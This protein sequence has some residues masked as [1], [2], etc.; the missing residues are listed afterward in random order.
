MKTS[1]IITNFSGGEVSRKIW[2][3]V[4]T[5]S[6]QNGCED[7]INWQ[8]DPHG[9]VL[10][11]AG[12]LFVAPTKFADKPTRL[13]PFVFSREDSYVL[14]FGDYYMRLYRNKGVVINPG[15]FVLYLGDG[16]ITDFF[17]PHT[18]AEV[19]PAD[20][21]VLQNGVEKTITTDYTVADVN[22]TDELLLPFNDPAWVNPSDANYSAFTINGSQATSAGG[23]TISRMHQE[24]TLGKGL[25][26]YGGIDITAVTYEETTVNDTNNN[27]V[28]LSQ[29]FTKVLEF[30]PSQDISQ[31]GRYS[32]SLTFEDVSQQLRTSTFNWEVRQGST[33]LN[34]GS[35]L[36]V[37]TPRTVTLTDETIASITKDEAL[38]VY[39][40]GVGD[41]PQ[42]LPILSGVDFPATFDVTG[43]TDPNAAIRIQTIDSKGGVISKVDAP[44]V[45]GSYSGD[46]AE[47]IPVNRPGPYYMVIEV[48]PY[49]QVTFDNPSLKNAVEGQMVTFLTAPADQDI[50]SLSDRNYV[51]PE[52]EAVGFA[53]QAIEVFEVETPYS[54]DEVFDLYYAQANDVMYIAH[55]DHKPR[56]L[57]RHNAYDWRMTVPTLVGAPWEAEGYLPVQGY[58]RV[59]TFWQQR[60]WFGGTYEEPQKLWSSRVDDY[61]QFE[62]VNTPGTDPPEVLPD[63][64]YSVALVAYSQDTIQWISSDRAL[65]VGTTVGEHRL[66]PQAYV[67][68]E[69][70][71]DVS[72]FSSFGGKRV[73]P[74]YMGRFTIYVQGSG[75]QIR[76]YEQNQQASIEVFDSYDLIWQAEH[77]SVSGIKE[78]EYQHFPYTTLF[79][80]KEDGDMLAVTYDPA[81]GQEMVPG[82][83]RMLTGAW[84]SQGDGTIENDDYKSVTVIPYNDIDQ[85]WTIVSRRYLDG[86]E[87]KW[88]Q[89][90]EFMDDEVLTDSSLTY[91]AEGEVGLPISSVGGLEHLVGRTVNVVADGAVHPDR[92]VA[93]DGTI[94]LNGEYSNLKI[95]LP[96]T[97]YLRTTPFALGTQFGFSTGH[98]KRW[99]RIW[100][101]LNDSVH[102]K[103]RY[104]NPEI[105][106]ERY[107]VTPMDTRQGNFTGDVEVRNLGYDYNGQIEVIQDIPLR[108]ELTAVFGEFN[109]E[110][111]S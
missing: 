102:P 37:T 55:P 30:V 106:K 24:L 96:Y 53:A 100:L 71:V 90:V 85:V 78:I 74:A 43:V 91:P 1:Q 60:L 56:R 65:L 14:E 19:I 48:D 52:V 73:R 15:D 2:G 70:P 41:D 33:V 36:L 57:E 72:R 81:V 49:L 8:L 97:C 34:S 94:E 58:P 5:A 45:V 104:V 68:P 87:V 66:A 62:P 61:H 28:A 38:A 6:Y 9:G 98:M 23:D 83:W 64:A 16:T 107:P 95:G 35:E 92:T 93:G 17:F 44:P 108:T 63:D 69:S 42:S 20:I 3:R 109:A 10:R 77:A 46:P 88:H 67:G 103:V 111:L 26:L 13:I 51:E 54:A 86:G 22:N 105:P 27:D 18:S 11:R 75:R 39:V 12:S 32:L 47:A 79:A 80:A 99:N 101:R 59:V 82:A 40:N 110:M 21:L 31:G 29:S 4:D 76:T 25:Y 7:L 84:D 50:I 89:Y